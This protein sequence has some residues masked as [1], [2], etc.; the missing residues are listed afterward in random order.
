MKQLFLYFGF[1]IL[2]LQCIGQKVDIDNH[3]I[4]VEYASLPE[5]FV[6]PE[7]RSYTVDVS[8][9]SYKFDKEDLSKQI[10]IRGWERKENGK[11]GI[12]L[13]ATDFVRG[14][15]SYNKRVSEK[16]DKEGKV[17]SKTNYYRYEVT[18]TGRA[19]LKVYGPVNKFDDREL[20]EKEQKK[21]DEKNSNP[22]LQNVDIDNSDEVFD[23]L[24]KNHDLSQTYRYQT[25]EYQTIKEASDEYKRNNAREYADQL[26]EFTST[27]ASRTTYELNRFY[28]YN[29]KRDWAKFKRLDSKKHPEYEMYD[30]A[31]KALKEIFSQKR[32]NKSHD[33]IKN[34][35]APITEYFESI[36][37]NYGSNDKH[38]KR[39]KA[40]SMYNLA[41]I[42]YYLDEP[43]KVIA[44]GKQYLNWGHDKKD[45]ERFIKKAKSLKEKLAFHEMP[46]RYFETNENADDVFLED[47]VDDEN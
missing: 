13:N 31:V 19:N 45:G 36:L 41:Q 17:I 15:S 22:F 6:Y 30:N 37:T 14:S 21:V 1:F 32:F 44:I 34:A 29:R 25:Q 7:D 39:L 9:G 18:N 11:V 24:A 23:N 16:K 2:S 3:R 27:L 40:A 38:Q 5:N 35:V 26:E 4:Y 10:T 28:G 20:T 46:G 47:V 12:K 33:N 43:D 8:A 42:Y